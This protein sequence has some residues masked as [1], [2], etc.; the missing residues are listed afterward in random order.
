MIFVLPDV[1]KLLS[2]CYSICKQVI[3]KMQLTFYY[4]YW[5]LRWGFP[6]LTQ[7]TYAQHV[8]E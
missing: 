7:A 8:N 2:K 3:V 1:Y 5:R 4:H 6:L